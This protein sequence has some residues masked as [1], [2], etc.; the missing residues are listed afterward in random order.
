MSSKIAVFTSINSFYLPKA[1]A[2]GRSVVTC[3]PEITFYIL[4]AEKEDKYNFHKLK[5]YL[6]KQKIKLIV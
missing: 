6:L 3:N 4:L 5:S 2:L 1:I